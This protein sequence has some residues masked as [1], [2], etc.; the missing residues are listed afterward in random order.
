M[1]NIKIY[2]QGAVM[3]KKIEGVVI[4]L[5]GVLF[6]FAPFAEW[7]EDYMVFHQAG[8]HIGGIAYLLLASSLAYSI[9]SWL[10]QPHLRLISACLALLISFYFLFL[11]GSNTSWGLMCLIFMSGYGA[12]SAKY[13][14]DDMKSQ[15]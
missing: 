5:A 4:G 7:H 11:A 9:F 13:E 15:D 2:E 12:V 6:W 8:N 10:S 14:I 1:L 3:N